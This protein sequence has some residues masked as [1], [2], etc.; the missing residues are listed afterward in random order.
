MFYHFYL[1]LD[2]CILNLNMGIEKGGGT[3]SEAVQKMH[4]LQKSRMAQA[5]EILLGVGICA[6]SL[7]ASF[8]GLLVGGAIALDGATRW[9]SKSGKGIVNAVRN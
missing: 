5:G 6:T 2:C 8:L 4:F 9:F 7:P 1:S 3:S